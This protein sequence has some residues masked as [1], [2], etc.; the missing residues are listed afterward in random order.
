MPES[1]CRRPPLFGSLHELPWVD[2]VNCLILAR[3]GVGYG[4]LQECRLAC[5]YNSCEE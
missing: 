1:S 5:P 3:S 2:S 4:D